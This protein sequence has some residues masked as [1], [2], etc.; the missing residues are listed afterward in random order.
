VS[1]E[2]DNQK[3]D[4]DQGDSMSYQDAVNI[5]EVLKAELDFLEDGG[6]GRSV[7]TPWKPTSTFLDSP[8]CLNFGDPQRTEACA[9]CPLMALVPDPNRSSS[10]PCHH[11]PLT[12]A[13][14]TISTV[15]GWADQ[16]ELENVVRGWLRTM[17]KRLEE[18]RAVNA[19]VTVSNVGCVTLPPVR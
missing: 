13:G 17:I 6:Y 2:E 7:R 4:H 1:N 9:N 3:D 15:Q 14:D 19:S 16:D 12:Q 11:I 18:D 10:V 5:L 8:T